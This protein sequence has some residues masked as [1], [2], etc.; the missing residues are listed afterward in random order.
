M[1]SRRSRPRQVDIRRYWSVMNLAERFEQVV[2][3]TLGA[4]IAAIIMMALW[5]LVREVYLNLFIQH[6]K[7]L[8]HQVFQSMFGSI[9]TL[10]IAMEFQHSIIKVIERREHIIQTRIVVLIAMLAVTRKFIILDFTDVPPL[11]IFALAAGILALGLVFWMIDDRECRRADHG[12]A[13]SNPGHTANSGE[14]Y[15]ES[16]N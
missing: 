8:S 14:H 13:A 3:T 16:G 1:I 2:A 11:M 5:E 9:M 6:E 15:A 12:T 10:L 7:V 4:V